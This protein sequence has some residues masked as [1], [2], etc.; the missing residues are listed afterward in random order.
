M[1]YWT[2]TSLSTSTI[3]QPNQTIT[4]HPTDQHIPFTIYFS[5]FF[6]FYYNFPWNLLL[7]HFPYLT[8]PETGQEKPHVFIWAI[9]VVLEYLMISVIWFRRRE[10][11]RFLPNMGM[12]AIL[13]MCLVRFEQLVSSVPGSFIWDFVTAGP[14]AFRCLKLPY[15][16]S[17]RSKVKKRPWPLVLTNPHVLNLMI[18]YT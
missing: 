8:L 9:S 15:Y 17:P 18:V 13:A 5:L 14:V 11:W 2:Q 1:F 16:E 4:T 7:E 10:F 3:V 6:N 12:M